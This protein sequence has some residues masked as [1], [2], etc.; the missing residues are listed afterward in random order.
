[1]SQCVRVMLSLAL[2][3]FPSLTPLFLLSLYCRYDLLLRC[4]QR[5]ASQRPKFKSVHYILS[6]MLD[7]EES[8]L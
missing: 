7:D 1:M 2:R 6:D 3:C 8:S 5:E 4:W